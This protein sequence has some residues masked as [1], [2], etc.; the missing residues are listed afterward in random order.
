MKEPVQINHPLGLGDTIMTAGFVRRMAMQREAVYVPARAFN[1]H[2]V[3]HM[4]E[5]AANIHVIP[6]PI[7]KNAIP[8]VKMLHWRLRGSPRRLR[9]DETYAWYAK[10]P[11]EVSWSFWDIRRHH[12][13]EE[14]L[15]NRFDCGREPFVFVHDDPSRG[16]TINPE[17]LPKGIRQIRPSGCYAS[18]QSFSIFHWL[19]IIEEA[20]EIHCIESSFMSIIDR[21]PTAAGKLFFHRY[22][23][24]RKFIKLRALRRREWKVL[25]N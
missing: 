25:R 10:E 15:F 24:R 23:R 16:L 18:S 1:R 5:G 13:A 9:L 6:S 2:S 21:T 19:R 20:T 12:A 4:Y 8:D 7:K 14:I 17:K 22:A 3:R 11:V